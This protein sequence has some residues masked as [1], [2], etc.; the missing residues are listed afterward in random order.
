M[1]WE[2]KRG[3]LHELNRLLRGATDT[4]FLD[5]TASR[6]RAGRRPLRHHARRRHAAAARRGR[7]AWSA[8]WRIRSTGRGSTP[9]AGRVVEGYAVLQPRVTPSLPVGRGRLAVPAHLLQ[10]SRHRSLRGGRLRRVPGPVRRRLLHRQGHLR[11]RRLRGRAAGP[12]ARQHAAQPRSVRGHLR[13]RRPGLRHRGRRGISRRAT[14]S[15]RRAS[16]AGRAA[17]G[18]CCPGCS[19]GAKRRLATGSASAVPLIGRWKMLDNLRRTLSAPA[20]VRRAGRRLDPAAARRARLDR[21]RPADDRAADAPAGPRGARAA[22]RR[23]HDAQPSRARLASD[24]VLAAGADRPAQSS[25][26]PTRPG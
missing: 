17:T 26:S 3:K 5:T 15:P 23:H 2:R 25:S 4:T 18:S 16:T 22:A 21:L 12:R 1:G 7:G 8:R 13:P 10:R 24:L 19:A 6:R 9:A 20:R 11:R 14:T